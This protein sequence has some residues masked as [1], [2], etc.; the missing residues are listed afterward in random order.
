MKNPTLLVFT[1]LALTAVV[2]LLANQH[3]SLPPAPALPPASRTD[4]L[5]TD[6]PTRNPYW[7]FVEAAAHQGIMNGYQ[8]GAATEPC[9]PPGNKRYFRPDA[10]I[11]RAQLAQAIANRQHYT[12]T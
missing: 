3:E 6:V 11:I 12:D 7:L 2:L 1:C 4:R 9:V 8:C 5:F 10:A